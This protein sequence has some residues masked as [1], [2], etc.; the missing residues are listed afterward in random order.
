MSFQ[1]LTGIT[2]HRSKFKYRWGRVGEYGQT[3]FQQFG[4][5]KEAA[6]KDFKSKFQ[7]K[8]KNAWEERANFKKF[9]GKYQLIDRHYDTKDDLEEARQKELKRKEEQEKSVL[10][11]FRLNFIG[12]RKLH[13]HCRKMSWN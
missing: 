2:F 3:K 12:L 13:L 4:T 1:L 7:Q 6:L 5:N 11:P 8:T 9:N 10:Y